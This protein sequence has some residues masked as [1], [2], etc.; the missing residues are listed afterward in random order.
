[1]KHCGVG[2]FEHSLTRKAPVM[3]DPFSARGGGIGFKVPIF[4]PVLPAW[5]FFKG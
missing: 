2:G 1:M 5:W 3:R 4:S